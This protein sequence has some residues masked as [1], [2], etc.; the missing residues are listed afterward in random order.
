MS[1]CVC[2]NGPEKTHECCLEMRQIGFKY[3]NITGNQHTAFLI[4][5]ELILTFTQVKSNLTNISP[6]AT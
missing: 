1:I 2:E 5:S 4:V 6:L 3:S